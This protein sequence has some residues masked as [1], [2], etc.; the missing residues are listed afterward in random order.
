MVAMASK[1]EIKYSIDKEKAIKIAKKAASGKF[2]IL[3]DNGASFKAGSPGMTAL[4]EVEDGVIYVSGGWL[5]G[6]I[7]NTIYTEICN[8]I[9]EANESSNST[10]ASNQSSVNKQ[11]LNIDTQLKVAEALI[12]FKQLFDSGIITEEEFNNKKKELLG[13]TNSQQSNASNQ[14]QINE[15]TINNKVLDTEQLDEPIIHQKEVIIE[16]SF[17]NGFPDKIFD[18]EETLDNKLEVTV[19]DEIYE[20]LLSLING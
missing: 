3:K 20:E 7:A 9:D 15:E 10:N 8:A 14:Q 4:V 12:K 1:K 16:N 18:E 13:Q 2:A 19:P 11:D 6:P 5:G 17:N